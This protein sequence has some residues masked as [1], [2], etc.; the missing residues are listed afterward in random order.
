MNKV[1][2]AMALAIAL[3][4]SA[5]AAE[6]AKK[7]SVAEFVAAANTLAA[8]LTPLA[9][10]ADKAAAKMKKSRLNHVE[11]QIAHQKREFLRRKPDAYSAAIMIDSLARAAGQ[12]LY[13]NSE[14]EVKVARCIEAA[15]PVLEDPASHD[16][17]GLAFSCRQS[18]LGLRQRLDMRR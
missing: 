8:C 14:I 15:C 13:F 17:Y 3:G 18:A 6:T 7:P 12:A 16:F 5:M 2:V 1:L 11:R 10:E 4:S 9:R